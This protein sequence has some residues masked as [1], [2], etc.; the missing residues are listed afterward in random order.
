LQDNIYDVVIIGGGPAGLTAAIYTA[1]AKLKTLLLDR[2]ICGGIP[3]TRERIENYPGFPE[4]IE[5]TELMRRF[6]EQ[7]EKFG[8]EIRELSE[9]KRV[10]PEGNL[11]KIITAYETFLAY[12]LIVASGSVP[13]ELNIPGEDKFK[14]RGVSYCAICDGP[15]YQ[16]RDVAV[17]GCG[18]M[19]LQEGETLLKYVK[20]ITFVETLPRIPGDKTL[21]EKISKD[22]RVR[23]FLNHIIT[24]INGEN[25][26]ESITIKDRETGEEKE[27]KVDGVF[28]YVGLT[29]GS[30]FLE[31]LVELDERGYVITD[32][33]M[34]TSLPGI[35]AV[36]DVRSKKVRQITVAC[37]EG[38]VAA[39]AVRDYLKEV[40]ER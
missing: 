23:F 39:I 36:G 31:G 14:G 16:D 34:R 9:V 10:E 1:R 8:G 38:T 7:A 19:G 29:P 37:G 25:V 4:G 2:A 28:I 32:E 26:V 13:K 6:K 40:K 21:Q 22:P 17:I 11:F 24:S 3:A 18:N 30:K 20:S 33:D 35:Y 12:S 15:L 27:I 5:G